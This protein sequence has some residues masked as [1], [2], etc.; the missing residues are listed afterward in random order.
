M[1]EMDGRLSPR[2]LYLWNADDSPQQCSA[3]TGDE[4]SFGIPGRILYI[5]KVDSP[6]S[7]DI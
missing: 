6:E 1:D 3:P 2:V 4:D 5:C 7:I